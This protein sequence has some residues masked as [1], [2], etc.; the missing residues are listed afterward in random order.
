[1]K[2]YS[3]VSIAGADKW[4]AGIYAVKAQIGNEVFSD[5]IVII[6]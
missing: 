5:R 4:P 3:S 2:G 6:K 1:L